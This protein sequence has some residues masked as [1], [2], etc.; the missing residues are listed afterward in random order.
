M[1]NQNPLD[2][3]AKSQMP[4]TANAGAVSI[5]IERAIAEARGQIQLAKMFPRSI[6]EATAEFL[7]SCRSREFAESAFYTVINRGSGP[8]IRFAEE[9][10]RCYGNMEYGH[11]ELSR[12]AG[13]SEV[14]V[15]AWD[16]QK[17]NFSKRQITVTHILDTK[18]GPRPLTQQA[19]IDNRIANVA[20]KQM[21]GRILALV[22]KSLIAEGIAMCQK[23]LAGAN[24]DSIQAR[25]NKMLVAFSSFGVNTDHIKQYIGHPLDS[26]TIDDISELT[27]V[28]NALKDGGKIADYFQSPELEKE[29]LP[30]TEKKKSSL[31]STAA[32]KA[33][34]AKKAAAKKPAP[35][36]EPEP[37]VEPEPE[38]DNDDEAAQDNAI[39]DDTVGDSLDDVF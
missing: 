18:Q 26:A 37:K 27:G 10:A 2:Q 16:K 11:R 30:D 12:S 23:T 19:D 9:V 3:N 24:Q 20:A 7:D 35:K 8:S 33:A 28:Y 5:E 29:S 13:K 32:K 38:V 15:Y 21:R 31:G 39:P 17:N 1:E 4:T 25:I 6:S 36:K 22:S 34:T 14:E